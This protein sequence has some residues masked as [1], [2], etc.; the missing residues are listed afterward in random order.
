MVSKLINIPIKTINNNNNI[1]ISNKGDDQDRCKCHH[2]HNR[3]NNSLRRRSSS[4]FKG[5]R[6]RCIIR[7]LIMVIID[8]C[9]RIIEVVVVVLVGQ[10][11]DNISKFAFRF[12]FF[13]MIFTI[14]SC[15]IIINLFDGKVMFDD[16]KCD[17]NCEFC[18]EN[19]FVMCDKMQQKEKKR[20]PQNNRN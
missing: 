18:L 8:H 10:T 11:I 19:K 16:S 1:T 5:R 14:I 3:N 13:S 2:H 4:R 7:Q 6:R 9:V 17:R 20:Q 15:I 12:L